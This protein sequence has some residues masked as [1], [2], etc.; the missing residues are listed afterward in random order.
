MK[1]GSDKCKASTFIHYAISLCVPY[2]TYPRIVD[3]YSLYPVLAITNKAAMNIHVQVLIST[4]AFILL[5]KYL[6]VDRLGYLLYI[7]FLNQLTN[8]FLKCLFNFKFLP[9]R[10]SS[11]AVIFLPTLNFSQS[12][13]CIVIIHGGFNLHFPNIEDIFLMLKVFSCAYLPSVQLLS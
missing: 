10:E 6:G 9:V 7:Q 11:F 2:F 13:K 1:P 12:K 5:D 8:C 4:Y 3:G